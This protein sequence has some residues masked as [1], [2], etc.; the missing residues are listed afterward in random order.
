MN[1]LKF[2][3]SNLIA[4]LQHKIVEFWDSPSFSTNKNDSLSTDMLS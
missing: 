4:I 3:S 2:I 1:F